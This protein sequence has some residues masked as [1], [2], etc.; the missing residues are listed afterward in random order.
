LA[1][2]RAPRSALQKHFVI[3]AAKRRSDPGYD[4]GTR[5]DKSIV[6]IYEG[7]DLGHVSFVKK[8]HQATSAEM[9]SHYGLRAGRRSVRVH[10]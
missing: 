7:D 2:K 1:D 9:A 8:A 6:Y 3:V 4:V 10:A 5:C